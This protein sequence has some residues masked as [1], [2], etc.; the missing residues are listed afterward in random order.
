M[1]INE[2]KLHDQNPFI[3]LSVGPSDLNC[4]LHGVRL[5]ILNENLI[6]SRPFVTISDFIRLDDMAVNEHF[7]V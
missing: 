2:I 6:N 7:A 3:E 5:L 4:S 1:K